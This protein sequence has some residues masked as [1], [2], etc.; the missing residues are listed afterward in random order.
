MRFLLAL[1]MMSILASFEYSSKA[2]LTGLNTAEIEVNADA[3]MGKAREAEL[4]PEAMRKSALTTLENGFQYFE[5]M[6][7]TG[8][9]HK[10]SS[11]YYTASFLRDVIFNIKMYT[12]EE[13][14][15]IQKR[16]YNA[17]EVIPKNPIN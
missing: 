7:G 10:Q 8:V 13:A 14:S 17:Q 15:R 12:A 11:R 4:R 9:V 16:L 1:L 2:R 5:V 3:M 6:K